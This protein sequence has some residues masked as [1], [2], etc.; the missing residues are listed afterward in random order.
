MIRI[1]SGFPENVVAVACEGRV[2][3]KDYDDVLVPAVTAGLQRHEKL[4]LYY[5]ITPQF[6]GMEA[7]AVWEDFRV[8]MGHLLRWER[9]TVVTDI[10]WIRHTV[11]VFRFLLPGKVRVF[12]GSETSA[13]R[14]WIVAS[15]A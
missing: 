6:S 1:L 3:R 10:E 8:G 2:T 15:E 13:A 12:T 11:N 5:E 7:G 14:K 9:I 4:R